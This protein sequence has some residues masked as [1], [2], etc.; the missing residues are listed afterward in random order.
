MA[1][2]MMLLPG[3]AVHASETYEGIPDNLLVNPDWEQGLE[4]WEILAD[5]RKRDFGS[6]EAVYSVISQDVPVEE[7]MTG[8]A[9]KLSG[10][11][12]A[13]PDD[14]TQESIYLVMSMC[15]GDGSIMVDDAVSEESAQLTYHEIIMDI[16]PEAAIV[17]I[18]ME[19]RKQGTENGFNF[20]DL[21]LEIIEK[22]SLQENPFVRNT[23]TEND[24]R[25]VTEESVPAI[26]QDLT[27]QGKGY[28]YGTGP[29]GY[30]RE[31]AR[32]C[33]REA[34]DGHYGEAWY[35]LGNLLMNSI[36]DERYQRAMECYEKACE[37]GFDLGL[38]GQAL[39]YENGLG[40][41]TDYAKA[42]E[43]YS[44][45]VQEGFTEGCCG[46]GNLYKNGDGAVQDEVTA[47]EYYRMAADSND[48]MW[49]NYAKCQIAK[50]YRKDYPGIGQNYSL[51]YDWYMKAAEEGYGSGFLGIGDM[52]YTGTGVE[53]DRA[54]ALSWYRKAAAHGN[55]TGM[56]DAALILAH[57]I[58]VD[59]DYGQ[60]FDYY[61]QAA[62]LGDDDAMYELGCMYKNGQSTAIDYSRA[63]YW[64]ELALDF[65]DDPELEESIGEELAWIASEGY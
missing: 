28:Y 42:F 40:T 3:I 58:G 62:E 11:I 12:A 65:T 54:Q 48:F 27:E 10:S 33:F 23:G 35:Y 38:V 59:Q 34:A 21:R 6:H 18:S 55:V 46:L 9:V 41:D 26:L 19:I 13:D 47:M 22:N 24:P 53:Q 1:I 20:N 60:A 56:Y 16:P 49:R 17:R 57:G 4:G 39:L 29:E 44:R 43:L 61:L 5:N 8:K 63:R 52:Y 37:Y 2:I 32:Q 31:K 15:A 7:D 50:M 14:P 36:E 25:P 51:A 45:A 64:L 30:D